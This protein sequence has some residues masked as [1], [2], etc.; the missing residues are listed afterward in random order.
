MG[1]VGLWRFSARGFLFQVFY[2][3]CVFLVPFPLQSARDFVFQAFYIRCELLITFVIQSARDFFSMR[4]SGGVGCKLHSRTSS[5]LARASFCWCPRS[6][7]VGA[8]EEPRSHLCEHGGTPLF[9]MFMNMDC[10]QLLDVCR[11]L[12]Q[13]C[14]ACALHWFTVRCTLCAPS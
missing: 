7:Q 3:W 11:C 6:W 13:C 9:S 14:G 4:F 8:V 2:R 1:G 10:S 12:I 5:A